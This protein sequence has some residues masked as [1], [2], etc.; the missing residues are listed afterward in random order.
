MEDSEGVEARKG[1][2]Q[3]VHGA[4][5]GYKAIERQ[6]GLKT[7]SLHYTSSFYFFCFS[8]RSLNCFLATGLAVAHRGSTLFS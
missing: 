4:Y 5:E 3:G 1:V 7:R 8:A 2:D 6:E